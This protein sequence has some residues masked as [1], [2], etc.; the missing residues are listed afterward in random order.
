MEMAFKLHG[1]KNLLFILTSVV[2]AIYEAHGLSLTITQSGQRLNITGPIMT[3]IGQKQCVRE[4]LQRGHCQSVNYWRE[5]LLC[6]L[7]PTTV[8]AGVGLLPDPGCIYMEK[9]SQPQV[10]YYY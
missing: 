8:I 3:I 1:Y 10:D 2:F 9:S 4:C 6:Q 5:R 7:N